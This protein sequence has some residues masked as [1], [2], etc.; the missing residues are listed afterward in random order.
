MDMVSA[1]AL[2][3]LLSFLALWVIL[4]LAS[5]FLGGDDAGGA[6]IIG[7]IAAAAVVSIAI[8]ICGIGFAISA[9]WMSV[10]A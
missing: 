7:A 1:I 3:G 4:F 2:T 5:I 6:A 10:P 9:I 8:L